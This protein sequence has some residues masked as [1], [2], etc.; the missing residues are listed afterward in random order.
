MDK[1]GKCFEFYKFSFWRCLKN[2]EAAGSNPAI[3]SSKRGKILY[4]SCLKCNSNLIVV[5]GKLL[6]NREQLIRPDFQHLSVKGEQPVGLILD[7]RQLCIN[8]AG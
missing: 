7:I 2:D 5:P 8:C 1:I 6:H 4:V 3:S